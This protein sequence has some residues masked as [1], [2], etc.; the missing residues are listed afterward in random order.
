M[1][2]STTNFL[3]L[4]NN[5]SYQWLWLAL[6]VWTLIFKGMA[7]WKAARNNQRNWFLA[8]LVFN[9]LGI[10]DIVYLFYFSKPKP[11][12]SVQQNNPMQDPK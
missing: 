4:L 7:L 12:D 11:K 3:D 2:I 8:I 6:I 9:T 10:L 5:P 1:S